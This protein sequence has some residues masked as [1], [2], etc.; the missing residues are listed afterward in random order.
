MRCPPA[1]DDLKPRWVY[2]TDSYAFDSYVC[3][4]AVH[5]G[6]MTYQ[7]GFVRVRID[8][9]TSGLRASIRNG[10]ESKSGGKG[11]RAVSFPPLGTIGC[12]DSS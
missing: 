7:G 6:R 11:L 5:A 2:G 8:K 4:A 1:S 12:V 9:T 10:I 3:Q